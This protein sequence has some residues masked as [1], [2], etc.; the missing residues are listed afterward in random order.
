MDTTSALLASIDPNSPLIAGTCKIPNYFTK[1]KQLLEASSS[2]LHP[3]CTFHVG[4]MAFNL[5][6]DPSYKWMSIEVVIK[7]FNL[8]DLQPALANFLK[9]YDPQADILP[10]GSCQASPPNL[11]L[12]FE[13]L[14]VWSK[15]QIQLQA[16]HHPHQNLPPQTVMASLPLTDWPLGQYDTV[17]VNTDLA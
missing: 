16:Y 9:Q 12:P 8:P 1:A 6:H 4:S 11:P 15:F 17:L 5:P 14:L 13:D 3:L 10:L 2:V 7:L